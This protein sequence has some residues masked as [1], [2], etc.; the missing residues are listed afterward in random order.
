MSILLFSRL[1]I[2]GD[3]YHFRHSGVVKRSLSPHQPWHSRLAREPQVQWLEQQVAKRR[4]KRDVFMEPTD[5]KFPQQW[6]LYNTNQRDLNVRQAWEQG[7]T[8]KGIV[9]SILDDGIEKNHP[10]LEGN[11]DPGASFDV[12]DQDPDPQPRYTQMNDNR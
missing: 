9:V 12:N 10:D 4:T 2:F 6:Y 1:Q 8:G 11:Y 5:P 3:Y 7:Y